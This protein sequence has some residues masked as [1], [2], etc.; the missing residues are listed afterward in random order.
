MNLAGH[1]YLVHNNKVGKHFYVVYL[2]HTYIKICA[3]VLQMLTH[4]VFLTTM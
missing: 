1:K 3:I 4:F 2:T